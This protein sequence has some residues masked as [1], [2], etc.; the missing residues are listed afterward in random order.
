MSMSKRF[1]LC[2]NIIAANN[3][4]PR[5][6]HRTT[7][8]SIIKPDVATFTFIFVHFHILNHISIVPYSI[9][10][11]K[12]FLFNLFPP[13]VGKTIG[14]RT[15]WITAV[16]P[17]GDYHIY[18]YYSYKYYAYHKTSARP[19]TGQAADSVWLTTIIGC[20][21]RWLTI[22]LVFIFWHKFLSAPVTF[23]FI[24]FP[25]IGTS[26]F[27]TQNTINYH[28]FAL[29]THNQFPLILNIICFQ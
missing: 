11:V 19:C 26:V 21:T 3:I 29:L 13:P 15:V 7:I 27:V 23:S 1:R 14:R 4:V 8:V 6:T 16:Y 18:D 20:C 24:I 9:N 25:G 2:D 17:T 22:Y 28:Y 5:P 10:S 12:L